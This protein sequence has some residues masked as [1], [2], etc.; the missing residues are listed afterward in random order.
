SPSIIVGGIGSGN[1]AMQ[2]A[3]AISL[4]WLRNQSL[5]GAAAATLAAD[6]IINA[7]QVL[8]GSSLTALYNDPLTDPRTPDIIVVP[9]LGTIYSTSS[10]K[11]WSMADLPRTTYIC[12]SCFRNRVWAQA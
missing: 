1:L 5:T 7:D 4:L 8:S 3:D 12:R 6:G 10:S 2:T 9:K 11:K